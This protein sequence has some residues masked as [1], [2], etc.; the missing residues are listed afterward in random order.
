M[1]T[2]VI[3]PKCGHEFNVEETVE[4]VRLLKENKD[5]LIRAIQDCQLDDEAEKERQKIVDLIK[6]ME[7]L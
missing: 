4:I 2:K 3:C 5:F 7:A 1:E 6:R